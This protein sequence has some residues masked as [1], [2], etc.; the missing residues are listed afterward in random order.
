MSCGAFLQRYPLTLETGTLGFIWHPTGNDSP[1]PHM[2]HGLT[3]RRSRQPCY[4]DLP[5]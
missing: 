1:F 2:H 4:T 5:I 3:V